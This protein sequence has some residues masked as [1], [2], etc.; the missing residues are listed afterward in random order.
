ME[1]VL[2]VG[3]GA[4]TPAGLCIEQVTYSG[5]DP[6][7]PICSWAQL[8]HPTSNPRRDKMVVSSI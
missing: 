4:R 8:Q 7:L 6:P 2:V 3:G 5:V 1:G